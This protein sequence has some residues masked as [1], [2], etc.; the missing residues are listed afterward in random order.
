MVVILFPGEMLLQLI[1]VCKCCCS[2]FRCS[3]NK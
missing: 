3:Y 2:V 1:G